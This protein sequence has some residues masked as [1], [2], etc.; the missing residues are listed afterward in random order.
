MLATFIWMHHC[1]HYSIAQ[2]KKLHRKC[3][4]TK[5]WQHSKW[6]STLYLLMLW[7]ILNSHIYWSLLQKHYIKLFATFQ[8][9]L[10]SIIGFNFNSNGIEYEIFFFLNI[11][12]LVRFSPILLHFPDPIQ[13]WIIYWLWILFF[14]SIILLSWGN[15]AERL[16]KYI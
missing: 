6:K 16:A 7:N 5:N 10:S 15:W 4:R 2:H 3:K 9:A 11:H 8:R 1:I 14:V 13:E 12:F